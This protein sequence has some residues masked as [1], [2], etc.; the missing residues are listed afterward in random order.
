MHKEIQLR[1]YTLFLSLKALTLAFS[2]F[3]LKKK[4]KT[5]LKEKIHFI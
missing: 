2:F 1:I 5:E 3:F 4:K